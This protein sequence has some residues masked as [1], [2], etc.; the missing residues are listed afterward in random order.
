[1]IGLANAVNVLNPTR[2]IVGGW[3]GLALLASRQP[4]IEE[5]QKK[6]QAMMEALMVEASKPG[7]TC[8]DDGDQIVWPSACRNVP[9]KCTHAG[10]K[11]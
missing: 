2:V 8:S 1:M 4:M 5:L 10:P 7:G 9:L 6:Q 11:A 3:A